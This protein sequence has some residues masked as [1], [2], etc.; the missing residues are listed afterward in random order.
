MR[1]IAAEQSLKA[2]HLE[3]VFGNKYLIYRQVYQTETSIYCR[4]LFS[5]EKWD[6]S[7]MPPT[8]TPMEAPL[9]CQRLPHHGTKSAVRVCVDLEFPK[10]LPHLH[11]Q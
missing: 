8:Y 3:I 9:P 10:L 11:L 7:T 5:P 2:T 4:V 1:G 6:R